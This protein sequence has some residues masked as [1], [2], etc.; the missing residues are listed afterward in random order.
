MN[1]MVRFLAVASG[2]E[3]VVVV[4]GKQFGMWMAQKII[5][6]VSAQDVS[7]YIQDK[8]FQA[9]LR[10]LLREE[11]EAGKKINPDKYTAHYYSELC[12]IESLPPKTALLFDALADFEILQSLSNLR[13]YL[14]CGAIERGSIGAYEIWE[15]YRK[16][17]DIIYLVTWGAGKK[18]E[19]LYWTRRADSDIELSVIYP[20]YNIA[21]YLEQCIATTTAWKADYVEFLF[22]DD[23]SPDNSAE[24][25][26]EAAK[27]DHRIKLLQKENGGCASARQYGLER[28]KGRY[29][30][31]IDPD[32]YIDE[33]MYHKLMRRAMTGGYEIAYSGYSQVYTEVGGTRQMPDLLGNPYMSGTCEPGDILK[34]CAFGRVAIWRGIYS[35]NM[36]K[37][38]KIHFYTD[39]RRF[40]D[41][42]FKFETLA[43]AKSV[44]SIPEHLY[45]Y[46]MGRPGQDVS[47][48][49]DRLYVHFPIFNYLNEFVK[50]H[51]TNELVEMLQVV[52]LQTHSYAIAKIKPEYLKEYLKRAHEDLISLYTPK[53]AKIINKRFLGK[54]ERLLFSVIINENASLAKKLARE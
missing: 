4:G 21:Q 30:G 5:E 10:K 1:G 16:G 8:N 47:A 26:K 39:L 2:I 48:D 24:I 15:N 13:P 23:G 7:F 22:V 40:D 11:T 44:V 53:D 42:P 38:T 18:D 6:E 17:S 51:G 31:F 32:D 25:V 36:I 28:A 3:H 12:E 52:K 29:V 27:K 14:L 33:T 54:R 45:Y 37:K 41:L 35:M 50:S 34:L 49:D 43:V 9:K 19:V 46:R 20:M